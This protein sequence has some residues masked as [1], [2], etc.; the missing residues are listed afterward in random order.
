MQ[1]YTL[2]QGRKILGQLLE[3]G[4]SQ[5]FFECHFTPTADYESVR[6]IFEQAA[7]SHEDP[8]L[9]DEELNAITLQIFTLRLRLIADDGQRW[10]TDEFLIHI[11][12]DQ[13]TIRLL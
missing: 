10:R 12:G 2:Q 6:E 13:A 3:I 1:R 9:S 11:D 7:Q 8:N 5:P 4:V